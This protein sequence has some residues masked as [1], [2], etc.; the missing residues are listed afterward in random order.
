MAYSKPVSPSREESDIV[1]SK[2]H[3]HLIYSH[4][5]LTSL[6]THAIHVTMIIYINNKPTPSFYSA[7]YSK[8]VTKQ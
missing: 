5:H 2:V 3:L 6:S 4:T 1:N 8:H 7:V